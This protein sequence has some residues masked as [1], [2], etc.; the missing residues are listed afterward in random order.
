MS[1]LN[2]TQRCINQFQEAVAGS[3]LLK[4]ENNIESRLADFMLWVD[5]VGALAKS[6]A[7]LDSRFQSRPDELDLVRNILSLLSDFVD[8]YRETLLE[9]L[10]ITEALAHIDSVIRNLVLI[11]VAIRRTGNASRSRRANKSFNPDEHHDFRRHLECLILLRP[12][13]N[14]PQLAKLE[15]SSINE[16]IDSKPSESSNKDDMLKTKLEQLAKFKMEDL[17]SSKLNEI[18]NRLI[19]ANLR[20]RHNFLFAQKRSRHVQRMTQNRMIAD[21]EQ[22]EV[23]PLISPEIASTSHGPT[24]PSITA[25]Q[26]PEDRPTKSKAPPTVTGHTVASTAEGTLQYNPAIRQR[27]TPTIARSQ[28]SFI[29]ANTEFP[30]PPLSSQD[31]G[32]FKYFKSSNRW[33]Q[34]LIEDLYPYT[35]IAQS[36]PTP[37]MLF[38]TRKAWELHVE[39]DHASQWQCLL[40]DEG[41]EPYSSEEDLAAHTQNEHK[42][43]LLKYELSFL[44]SSGEGRC[45]GI[46]SCPLCPSYGPRDS[47]ELV[48]HVVRHAYEFALRAL[49]WPKSV[50][51]DLNKPIGTFSLSGDKWLATIHNSAKELEISSFDKMD[52]SL[53]ESDHGAPT[54]DYFASN[55][56]FEDDQTIE[57]SKCRTAQARSSIIWT[58]NNNAQYPARES[59]STQLTLD[60]NA[61]AARGDEDAVR[62][63]IE[64]CE[65]FDSNG[66]IRK[67]ALITATNAGHIAVVKQL[68][69]SGVDINSQNEKG[70]TALFFATK[71][72]DISMVQHLIASGI[73]VTIKDHDDLTALHFALQENDQN[74]ISALFTLKVYAKFAPDQVEEAI[75]WAGEQGY[76]SAASILRGLEKKYGKLIAT[77]QATSRISFDVAAQNILQGN[78]WWAY[79]NT[80]MEPLYFHLVD[81]VQYRD[82]LTCVAYSHDGKYI[83]TG[84]RNGKVRIFDVKTRQT[85]CNLDL[86]RK[87]IWYI[88]FSLDGQLIFIAH[89]GRIE[90]W[91]IATRTF[92]RPFAHDDHIY[93]IDASSDG[94]LLACADNSG[95]VHIWDLAQR[96]K[97][98]TFS[99]H[100]GKSITSFKI[101]PDSSFMAAGCTDGTAYIWRLN[102]DTHGEKKLYHG[103]CIYS[104]AL[105]PGG[106][107]LA[108]AGDPVLKLWDLDTGA[109][110]SD[111]ESPKSL[112]RSVSMTPDNRWIVTAH[113][114][115]SVR[116]W[117]WI[118]GEINC[119]FGT[120]ASISSITFSPLDGH[121]AMAQYDRAVRIWS[122]GP[123]S[124]P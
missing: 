28:I 62:S 123:R 73:D 42:E 70:W 96:I 120:D 27:R 110:I 36:C 12:N 33:R 55:D 80:Q 113:I 59:N 102:T 109:C 6:G 61:A 92:L 106:R 107:Y 49:P 121:F 48:D 4:D 115:G 21:V 63:L 23:A 99:T 35:C 82:A 114:D 1:V 32:V 11:G 8:E 40:C 43:E 51:E 57:S 38:T 90:L 47:P 24:G 83:A 19:D 76:R 85:I 31:Q 101:S 94:C 68:L 26:E 9:G 91:N 66:E 118:T 41:C 50:Q 104:I 29:A 10:S 67:E 78:G 117:D 111:F 16:L 25:A 52:H 65:H 108:T 74:I 79:T 89:G 77:V 98:K 34:H 60:L 71:R 7:S 44:V 37:D 100:N 58:D 122:Y 39:K 105:S 53:Q 14:E 45:M 5:T 86:G 95:N 116:F 81:T 22:S 119:V 2:L 30:K 17:D 87:H 15:I 3:K 124:Q 56:Y 93:A 18:Q 103:G 75:S 88:C 13:E 54:E 84:E 112:I 72:K 46:E 20:R 97:V 69:G 64:D